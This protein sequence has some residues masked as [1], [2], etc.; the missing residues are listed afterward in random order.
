MANLQ[1]SNKTLEAQAE[2]LRRENERL[3]KQIDGSN[4]KNKPKDNKIIKL[5]LL[6]GIVFFFYILQDIFHIKLNQ[7]PR[8]SLATKEELSEQTLKMVGRPDSYGI[9]K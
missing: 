2:S 9:L 4:S 5:L 1:M 3:Q 8:T 6:L 7:K